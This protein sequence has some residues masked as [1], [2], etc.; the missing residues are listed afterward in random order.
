MIKV[1]SILLISLILCVAFVAWLPWIKLKMFDK[2]LGVL[3]FLLKRKYAPKRIILWWMKVL[4][5]YC[6]IAGGKD[7]RE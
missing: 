1:F 2:M 6:T 5:L 3:Q 7:N 4:I